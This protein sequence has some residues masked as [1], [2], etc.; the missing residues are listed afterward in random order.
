MAPAY[1]RI[2]NFE[3][4]PPLD[5]YAMSFVCFFSQLYY[6]LDAIAM[7]L[8][9]ATKARDKSACAR[10]FDA[11]RRLEWGTAESMGTSSM[12][13]ITHTKMQSVTIS[14]A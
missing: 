4:K 6:A 3:T 5:L 8:D 9:I 2:F 7:Q 10:R 1:V 14:S 12:L 13:C 11:E